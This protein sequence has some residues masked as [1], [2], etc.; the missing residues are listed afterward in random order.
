MIR[1]FLGP[2]WAIAWKDIL[3]EIRTKEIVTPVVVFAILV[4]VIFNFAIEP[5]PQMV[6]AVAPGI[7]WVAFTFAGILGLNRTFSLEK[8]KG[9][10]DGLMLCP[11]SR[12]TIYFGKV[13]GSYL[14]MLAVEAIMLPVFAVLFNLSLFLPEVILVAATATLGFAAVGTVF[15]AMAANTRSRE[16]MLP[17]LFFPIALPVVIAAVEGTAGTL[18]GDGWSE[19]GRWVQLIGVFDVIFLVVSGFAFHF[20]L[21]E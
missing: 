18:R 7:L 14:F 3:L 21:E 6:A 1:N 13:L 11:V 10:L 5:T 12:D 16:I 2:I 20:A 8:D 17:V 15:S 4:V 19:I 9:S